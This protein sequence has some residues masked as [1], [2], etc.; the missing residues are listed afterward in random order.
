MAPR[1]A[2]SA[3]EISPSTLHRIEAGGVSMRA[4]DVE[5]M[6][7]VYGAPAELTEALMG[8]AKETKARGWWHSY[9]DALPKWFSLYVGM[10]SAATRLRQYEPDMIPGLLQSRQ[11]ATAVLRLDDAGDEVER[12]VAV[13][14]ERQGLLT[15]RLPHAPQLDVILGEVALRRSLDD[16]AA[17]AEQLSYLN[18]AGQLS[19]VSIRVLP[20]DIGVHWAA[21]VGAFTIME[22]PVN[23]QGRA[24]EPTIVYSEGL[25]GALYLDKASEVEAYDRLW[26]ETTAAALDEP[27]SRELIA[28]I[29]KECTS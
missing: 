19:N 25:T 17:M 11:Y 6:C 5:Q 14:L 9:G 23:G 28:K 18:E 1:A 20:L 29:A 12:R 10:E 16:S 3:L 15:R 27:Q 24:S 21:S 26:T 22:F 2:A 4:L 7:K 13:R 8:L